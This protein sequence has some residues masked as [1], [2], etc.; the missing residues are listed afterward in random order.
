VV[1]DGREAGRVG[2]ALQVEV[3]PAQFSGR[4]STIRRVRRSQAGITS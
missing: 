1:L 4:Q 2:E 3:E